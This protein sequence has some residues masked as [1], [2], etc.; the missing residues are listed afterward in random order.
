MC[1][2]NLKI[3][4]KKNKHKKNFLANTLYSTPTFD[5]TLIKVFVTSNVINFIVDFILIIFFSFSITPMNTLIKV[6]QI[7]HVIVFK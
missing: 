2:S 6:S 5:A 4:Q 7:G 3:N 1:E